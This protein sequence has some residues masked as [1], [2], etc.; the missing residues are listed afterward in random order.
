MY[1][2]PK[3]LSGIYPSGT[4]NLMKV[5]ADVEATIEKTPKWISLLES[6]NPRS[7][8]HKT[9][10]NRDLFQKTTDSLKFTFKTKKIS[11]YGKIYFN[12]IQKNYPLIID[13]INMKGEVVDTQYLAFASENCVFENIVPGEYNIRVVEDKNENKKSS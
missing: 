6:K 11:E 2:K 10:G 8:D 5:V 3:H 1:T 9:P 12:P 4:V 7:K 13:L